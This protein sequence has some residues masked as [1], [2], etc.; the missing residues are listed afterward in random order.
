MMRAPTSPRAGAPR[1][2]RS[3]TRSRPGVALVM[4]VVAMA[5]L[6]TLVAG[7]FFAALREQR[8][9]R[10]A[11]HRVQALAAAEYGVAVASS[12]R[13]WRSWWNITARRGP[14]RDMV[15]ELDSATVD[16][17][18]LWKLERNS[19]I[20]VSTG[21]AGDAAARA[22]RRIALLLAL[23]I[24]RLRARSAAIVRYGI[25][26]ADSS[27][28][29]GRDSVPTG[30]DC[31]PA[32]V[33]P[34]AVI[35][36]A[37]SLLDE[38]ACTLLP[39][40][41]GSPPLGIDSLAAKADTYERFGAFERDSIADAALQLAADAV[42]SAPSPSLDA[43]GECDVARID[44]LGDPLRV[45]GAA[46]PCAD[47]F[48]VLHA[49]GNMRIEGGAGQGMLLVD[50]NLIIGSGARF[51]GVAVV[52]GVLEI[53]EYS[54]LAGA[55]LASSVVVRGGSRVSY[56]SCAVERALRGAAEPVVPEGPA[57]SELY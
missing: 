10:D 29:T 33:E 45:L 47:Y 48:P 2:G 39:C 44:N 7:V 54:K 14:L 31:P 23:R 27:L 41:D 56:S 9:G 24:P 32:G 15:F 3:L 53:T 25:V 1:L 38:S 36:Q 13:S 11:I 21:S 20:L 26:V 4:A 5:V 35:A 19:F 51:S 42:L 55:I 16:S 57:W 37:A 46:S 50:G 30:W 40:V 8:D 43:A 34:P 52:R 22:R 6:G 12:P 28:V 18:R 17:V 49:P